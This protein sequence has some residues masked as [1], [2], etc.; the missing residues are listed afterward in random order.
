MIVGPYNEQGQPWSCSEH[1]ICNG[2]FVDGQYVYVSTGT[3][4]YVVG[5]WGPAPQQ[6]TKVD[7]S[8][9]SCFG[10]Y[11]K[12]ITTISPGEY[13]EIEVKSGGGG[14]QGGRGGGG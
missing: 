13:E 7:C 1:D 11:E 10:E 4:P 6:K 5:C 12:N 14:G 9:F 2:A 3:F 8:S